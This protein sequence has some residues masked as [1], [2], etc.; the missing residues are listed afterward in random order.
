MIQTF[1]RLKRSAILWR[2]F[3][4][5]GFIGLTG[6]AAVVGGGA[7]AGGTYTYLQGELKRTMEADYD[8]VWEATNKAVKD[9]E[10]YVEETKKSSVSAQLKGY[11][12]SGDRFVIKLESQEP[13][14][15]HVRI[16]I[17]TLGDQDR[18]ERIMNEIQKNL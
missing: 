5:F 15:V 17:G 10:L 2:S 4:V 12:A 1:D 8:R 3:I 13:E 6:C 7:G 18:S 11:L 9:M 14:F 16:R